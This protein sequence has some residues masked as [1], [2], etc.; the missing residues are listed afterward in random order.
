M[1]VCA[2]LCIYTYLWAPLVAQ[3]VK[4]LPAMQ[5]IQVQSLGQEVP[6]ERGMATHSSILAWRIPWTEEPGGLQIHR[7]A[8][9][10]T[11]LSD[12]AFMLTSFPQQLYHFIFL[13]AMYEVFQYAYIKKKITSLC[14]VH[15]IFVNHIFTFQCPVSLSH[16]SSFSIFFYVI[17]FLIKKIF[18]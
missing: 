10:W 14:L 8:R 9:S 11:L 1:C 16:C 18:Y 5:E 3:M 2:R 13:S 7:T 4:N 12:D 17:I 6:L 15:F